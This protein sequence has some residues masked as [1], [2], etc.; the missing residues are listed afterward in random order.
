MEEDTKTGK[1]EDNKSMCYDFMAMGK[2]PSGKDC[3]HKHTARD[4][5]IHNRD[6]ISK[7]TAE[8]VAASSKMCVVVIDGHGLG[9]SLVCVW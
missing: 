3:P 1:L 5:Y 9:R 7:A 6:K 2:C 4:Q 8:A